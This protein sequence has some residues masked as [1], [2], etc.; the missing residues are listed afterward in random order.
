[1][2]ITYPERK[3]LKGFIT[4]SKVDYFVEVEI[5]YCASIFNY[6]YSFYLYKK[7]DQL[8][9]VPFSCNYD[10]LNFIYIKDLYKILR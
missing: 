8:A 6:I 10:S 2:L 3:G 9:Y 4:Y 5:Q 7:T 1:M